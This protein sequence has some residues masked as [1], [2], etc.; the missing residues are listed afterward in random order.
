MTE[1]ELRRIT[2]RYTRDAESALSLVSLTANAGEILCIVGPSGC[3]K[4]TLLKVVSGILAPESGSVFFEGTDVGTVPPED[5]RAVMVFQHHLLFPFMSVLH[6]VG[7]G[8]RMHGVP[9]P[10]WI[11]A[12]EKQLEAVQLSNLAHRRPASLSGGQRQRVA[13]ARALVTQPRV[14]LLDEPLA[15][16][17]RHLREE[18]RA[19]IIELQRR[20][21]TT[22][23][24]VT[25]DQEEA[26]LLGDRIAMLDEGML[27][28]HGAAADFYER[29]A[30]TR[31]A[32]FFGNHNNLHGHKHGD[33]V[34]TAV[35]KLRVCESGHPD[36]EA[37]AHVRPESLELRTWSP[38]RPN[39]LRGRITH[40][41]YVGTH[42]RY[43][44]DV[45]GHPWTVVA[46][47]RESTFTEGDDVGIHIPPERVWLTRT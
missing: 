11:S 17:D 26:V 28:Q 32:R 21:Q 2:V 30:S 36:G 42:V 25:H 27:L 4:T 37:C 19:V 7:F 43:T 31:V 15:N 24:C 38:G 10:Q 9:K 13:L 20:N 16:L 35:G 3:G 44:V 33:L 47:H 29:P 41:V 46:P 39:T 5:R 34:T 8:L 45:G 6:N 40:R 22:T 14:L 1:V 23:L 18:M 12:A